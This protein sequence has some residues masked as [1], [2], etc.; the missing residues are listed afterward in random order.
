M[1]VR[2]FA[3]PLLAAL[4]LSASGCSASTSGTPATGASTTPTAA[5]TA[6]ETAQMADSNP[7]PAALLTVADVERASGLSGLTL[8]APN[9]TTEAIG[10]LNFAAADGTLVAI[11]NIGDGTAFGQSLSGMNYSKDATGTGDMCYVG[12]SPKVSPVL[13]IFAAAAGD[14]AVMMKTFVKSAGGTETW[15]TIDQLKQLVGLSLS[16]WGS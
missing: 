1:R 5:A 10:R 7:D 15:V 13:T 16:R 3:L 2:F 4:L 12:P 8:I 11:M 14:R 9:T 6:S